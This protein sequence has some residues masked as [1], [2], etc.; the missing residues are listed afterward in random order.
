MMMRCKSGSQIH[1]VW[2]QNIGKKLV[3][4]KD[5]PPTFEKPAMTIEN[6][7]E[8]GNMLVAEKDNVKCVQLANK[9]MA[10]DALGE[11]NEDSIKR[12]TFYGYFSY[13]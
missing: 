10:E 8:Y 9:Y 3:N 5:G 2:I 12:G 1:P 6:V 11:A 4:S 13:P 7:L